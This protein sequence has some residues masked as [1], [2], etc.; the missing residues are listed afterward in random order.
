MNNQGE[1]MEYSNAVSTSDFILT[2][3][4]VDN[5]DNIYFTDNISGK[6][7]KFNTKSVT[8]SPVYEL[9]TELI[10]DSDVLLK[11][12]K[13]LKCLGD[14]VFYGASKA[15][16]KVY[17]VKC[18]GENKLVTDIRGKFFPWGILIMIVV[19]AAI[20]GLIYLVRYLSGIEIKR[21]PLAVRIVTM[22]LPIYLI[23]MGVLVYVN[24]S[25]GVDEYMSV[26]MSEQERGAKTVA[27]NIVGSD[28]TNLNHIRGYMSPEYV[29]VKRSVENG[30]ADLM[31]KIGDR[32][33]YIVTYVER[34]NKL[35]TT[36]NTNFSEKS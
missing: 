1:F 4:S 13:P 35:Y 23:S 8:T 24:T 12:V 19:A 27:D 15:F 25:D 16:D 6:F 33:D 5:S 32:S 7:Y 3:M 29:K 28:F 30:Y 17:Y 36:I 18:G 20:V 14:G 31:L 34:Y 9:S 11:D 10:S 21:I 26:L 2:D 22:F